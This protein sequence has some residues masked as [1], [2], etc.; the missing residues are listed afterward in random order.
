M[1][2]VQ[3]PTAATSAET[4]NAVDETPK[5]DIARDR[6]IAYIQRIERLREEI[7]DLQGDLSEIYKEAKGNGFDV[8]ALKRVVNERAK[9]QADR[10]EAEE[11]FQL[12]WSAAQS[13]PATSA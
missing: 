6:I 4:V 9:N 2:E 5:D 8:K 10:D 7:K 13:M 1:N 12:Y 11:I 3:E